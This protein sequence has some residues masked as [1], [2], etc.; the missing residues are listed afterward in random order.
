MVAVSFF[1]RLGSAGICC[2]AEAQL[3]LP[4]ASSDQSIKQRSCLFALT[5]SN[6]AERRGLQLVVVVALA[7]NVANVVGYTKCDKDA[8]KKLT[9]MAA[10]YSKSFLMSMIGSAFSSA[11]TPANSAV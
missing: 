10:E 7:L 9:G 11:T 5:Q 4:G 8:K 6:Y 1:G 3:C 2:R